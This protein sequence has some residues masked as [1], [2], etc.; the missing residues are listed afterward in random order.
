M[1][2]FI[3]GFPKHLKKRVG[4]SYAKCDLQQ[5][6]SVMTAGEATEHFVNIEAVDLKQAKRKFFILY[7][8]NFAPR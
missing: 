3:L 4:Y 8:R 1:P 5:Y 7:R 2:D 6:E